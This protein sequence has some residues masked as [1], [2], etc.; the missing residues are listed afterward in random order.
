MRLALAGMDQRKNKTSLSII[1]FVGASNS[2]DPYPFTLFQ[3]LIARPSHFPSS[4]ERRKAYEGK[5]ILVAKLI[6]LEKDMLSFAVQSWALYL[7]K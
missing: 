1:G 4:A 3:R 7:V 2:F 5:R 6:G